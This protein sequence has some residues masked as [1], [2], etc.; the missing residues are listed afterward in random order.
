MTREEEKRTPPDEGVSV[1]EAVGRTG[2]RPNALVARAVH[3]GL[4]SQCV[5]PAAWLSDWASSLHWELE[6]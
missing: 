1:F 5:M 3:L 2:R 4:E 6:V